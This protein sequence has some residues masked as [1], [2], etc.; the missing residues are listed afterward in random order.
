[1]PLHICQ[2]LLKR[3]SLQ[4]KLEAIQTQREC[5]RFVP[6]RSLIFLFALFSSSFLIGQA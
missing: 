3:G 4:I 6:L 2:D 5:Q 1:M